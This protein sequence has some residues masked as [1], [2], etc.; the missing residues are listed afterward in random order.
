MS[1]NT[2]LMTASPDGLLALRPISP[3]VRVAR[4]CWSDPGDG[5]TRALWG[6]GS[7]PNAWMLLLMSSVATLLDLVQQDSGAML[8]LRVSAGADLQASK[9]LVRN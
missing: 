2:V 6:R 5:V 1:E 3:G 4:I 7:S 8:K 9:P